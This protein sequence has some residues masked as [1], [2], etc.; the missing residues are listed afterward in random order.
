MV[1]SSSDEVLILVPMLNF[2]SEI[3]GQSDSACHTV[4]QA[5]IL[6]MLLRIYVVFP[7]FS[8][9][10]QQDGDLKEALHDACLLTFIILGQSPQHQ[11]TVLNHSVSILWT[12]H[13]SQPFG[14]TVDVY[15]DD[16]CTA[17][18]QVPDS[19]VMRREIVIYKSSL[20][21]QCNH[22]EDMEVCADIAEF[23]K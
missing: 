18:R 10:T 23:T 22:I 1:P 8:D 16:R 15:A 17:W 11:R 19:Y 20:W 5:D 6:D 9:T 13:H 21:K 3:A 4:L 7:A 2:I 14:H 12:E